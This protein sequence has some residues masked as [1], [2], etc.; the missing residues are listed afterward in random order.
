M[1]ILH[2]ILLVVTCAFLAASAPHAAQWSRTYG[3]GTPSSVR[4][5]ADGGYILAG[6][7]GCASWLM[8]LDAGGM[9]A[10]KRVRGSEGCGGIGSTSEWATFAQLAADGGYTVLGNDH[11]SSIWQPGQSTW[12]SKLDSGGTVVWFKEYAGVGHIESVQPTADGGFVAAGELYVAPVGV[13]AVV[14][15]FDAGGDLVWRA[16]LNGIQQDRAHFVQATSDGGAVVAGHTFPYSRA[17]S[18]GPVDAWV[19]KLDEHGQIVW[20]KTYG[21]PGYDFANFVSPTADG[22]YVVVGTTDSFGSGGVDVWVWKLDAVGSILWQ[23]TYGGPGAEYL[24][25]AHQAQDGG[26]IVAGLTYSFGSGNSDA[27]VFKIDASGG[28]VWQRTFGGTGDD[29]TPRSVEPTADGGYAIAGH[30]PAGLPESDAPGAWVLKLDA[31]GAINGCPNTNSSSAAV[32]ESHATAQEGS[33]SSNVSYAPPYIGSSALWGVAEIVTSQQCYDPSPASRLTA[34]EYYYRSFDHY[35]LT[36]LPQEI[37][38]LDAGA[39]PGWTRTGKSFQTYG[40]DPAAASVCRFWSG[41]T[42]APKSSHFYTPYVTECAY[43]KQQGVW[44]YESDVFALALPVGPA[45]QGVCGTAT[46]P[47][48]RAYNNGMS[49]APNHR[50]TTDPAVL[51]AMVAQGWSMEGEASTRVFA[52]VPTQQ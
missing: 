4:Q 36:T 48:Y 14:L 31:N 23:R 37:A 24:Y 15:R 29:R 20:Q 30:A 25:A 42:F 27:W 52:C 43:L 16:S 8:R 51:D 39:F 49:G 17:G 10:W 40:L 1:R 38:A 41:Q 22:G 9:G 3:P 50:Y 32:L 46:Q 11:F 21:G 44:Q 12:I 35:F 45:G 28:I 13:N 7:L 26:L 6:Y 5:T 19:V 33:L 18:A 2:R 47:L 34:V